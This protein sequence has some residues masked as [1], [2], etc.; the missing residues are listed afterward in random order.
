[1]KKFISKYIIE[2]IGIIAIAYLCYMFVDLYLH[3]SPT[4]LHHYEK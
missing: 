2:I 1:M 4:A 3:Y